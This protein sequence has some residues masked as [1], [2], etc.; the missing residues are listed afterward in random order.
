M[1]WP[2][3]VQEHDP[4]SWPGAFK[5][6]RNGWAWLILRPGNDPLRA[7]ATAFT[8]IW[9]NDATDPDR[10]PRARQWAEGLRKANTL[11][12]LIDATQDRLG[13]V[14]KLE[15]I[16]LYV[17]QAEELYSP[18]FAAG[19]RDARRFSELLA[20]AAS[21]P[22]LSAFA[23]LRGDYFDKLQA[24]RPLFDVYEHVNVSPLTEQGLTEVVTKPASAL[25]IK[26]DGQ[27]VPKQIVSAAMNAA[28][29]LPLLSYLL[30]DMWKEM[31]GR[32]DGLL[33][34][35]GQVINIGGVLAARAEEYW[36]SQI[37]AEAALK[38]LLTLKLTLTLPEGK[39]VRRL[40]LRSE[41]TDEEWAIAETLAD[42]RWRLISIGEDDDAQGQV[43]AEVA[44][45]ALLVG[46]PRLVEWL[47]DDA[48]FLTFKTDVERAD[49][50]W[51][52]TLNKLALL[53]GLDLTLAEQWMSRR[54][55]DLSEPV[56]EFI[57]TSVDADREARKKILRLALA[58]VILLALL[59]AG[60]GWQWG[61]A[62]H[63]GQLLQA[64]G[65][66][67]EQQK[68]QLEQQTETLQK[69]TAALQEQAQSLRLSRDEL[70]ARADELTRQRDETFAAQSRFLADL[71]SKN[72][73]AGNSGSAMLYALAA[74]PEGESRRI[75]PHIVLE[76][77]NALVHAAQRLQ[78]MFVLKGHEGGINGAVFSPDGR[79]ILTASSDHTARV[80]DAKTG[81]ERLKL[82]GHDDAV[83][84]AAYSRDGGKVV[85]GSLDGSA[86]IWDAHS[87]QLL[88]TLP[89]PKISDDREAGIYG[90][91]FSFDGSKVATASADMTARV[92]DTESG[93]ELIVLKGHRDIVWSA[94]FSPDDQQ[95][96]TASQ[97]G[98]ACLWDVATGASQLLTDPSIES[99]TTM[100]CAEGV[101]AGKAVG[102]Q[103]A[104]ISA[105]YSRDGK[106][107]VTA[108]RDWT[109]VVWSAETGHL[110]A[111]LGGENGHQR[112]VKSA[113]FSP[114]GRFALTSSG[115]PRDS[116]D[117]SAII[118]EIQTIKPLVLGQK[119]ED[120]QDAINSGAAGSLRGHLGIIWSATFSPN[121]DRAVTAS[122]DG[123]VRT[124]D[125]FTG[126]ELATFRGHSRAVV[127]ASFSPDGKRVVTASADGT[128]R[129]W[130]AEKDTPVSK[131]GM[132][133]G[134][135]SGVL[136]AV[137]SPDGRRLATASEDCTARIWDTRSGQAIA[138]LDHA[139]TVRRVSFSR[140]GRLLATA[141]DDTVARIWDA[142]TFELLATL[143][144]LPSHD[145]QRCPVS[146]P[147][148]LDAD[149]DTPPPAPAPT[150]AGHKDLVLAAELNPNGRNLVTASEDGTAILW[151]VE[152]RSK[153]AILEGHE[154]S[155]V[156]AFFRADGQQI[157]TASRDTTARIWDAAT[158]A[159]LHTLSGHDRELQD[160]VF[161]P[162]GR[163]I[164][165][166]AGGYEDPKDNTAR[167]W[168]AETGVQ[169]AVLKG[170]EAPVSTARFSTDARRILTASEDGT[171]RLW[172]AQ[173]GELIAVLQ[174]HSLAV[175][176]ATFNPDSTEVI[177]TSKD[178]TARLW[179][180]AV[181][182]EPKLF[183]ILNRHDGTVW[184]AQFSPDGRT[185]VTS[186]QDRFVRLWDASSGRLLVAQDDLSQKIVAGSPNGKLILTASAKGD[187]RIWDAKTGQLVKRLTSSG[188][189]LLGAAFLD[190]GDG[191]VSVAKCDTNA[192]PYE[193]QE[194]GELRGDSCLNTSPDVDDPPWL[195]VPV[196]VR[197]L[198]SYDG[199]ASPK[200]FAVAGG[201]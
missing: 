42:Q 132:F 41:C 118:W 152:S 35:P 34:L 28:G 134:H 142:E 76:A 96:V 183:V 14:E 90:V 179:N 153:I 3:A 176:S 181:E 30:T 37:A 145:D 18:A 151:D 116:T 94:R 193:P 59:G 103:D 188:I 159:L 133:V 39:H 67:L 98:T 165:T 196:L 104:V 170:H 189:E 84:T 139:D 85:T 21:D 141:S 121:G 113:E 100:S 7:L 166:A 52:A 197:S 180:I 24:D 162:D 60:L 53:K 50:R 164:A 185:V 91:E 178:G 199:N 99:T 70:K 93:N 63:R 57:R 97:D 82:V 102:H 89:R 155:V 129:I 54:P 33:K 130:N 131:F 36:R 8:R 6:S 12:D 66:T 115:S 27:E 149:N 147:V 107:I 16:L 127:A 32:S 45:E 10:G 46:W 31:V 117:N 47:K 119:A 140:D 11:V 62:W 200:E 86:R 160:A 174:G 56:R 75:E 137:F 61:E 114:D 112:P 5:N 79:S 1:K 191:L 48:E 144:T 73:T 22:R 120:Y 38:R 51:R 136:S 108:S 186:S 40:A 138:K 20:Q 77:E 110:I 88:R 92:W 172:D 111:R 143:G 123:T 156:S 25:G 177:T 80:W 106:Q 4:R 163:W 58:A 168:D 83:T 44:H 187:L 184:S 101:H 2:A 192:A 71:A 194:E 201:N 81:A 157:V 64:Q 87:G 175:T 148:P 9:F 158:G 198:G 95:I 74:L 23:S 105:K 55:N 122:E 78:E 109:A 29:A 182:T 161:S 190:R 72:V 49:R 146:A 124:W 19:S 68:K 13:G 65:E 15:R 154:D 173:S 135:G 126:K 43:A 125:V 167:V 169:R 69:Q 150:P 26:F 17:D 171:A 128:A 195:S